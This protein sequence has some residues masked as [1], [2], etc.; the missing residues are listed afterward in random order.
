MAP[1]RL[2]PATSRA[3]AEHS[4]TEPTALLV[5]GFEGRLYAC[6]DPGFF[7][8]VGQKTVWT[9]FFFYLSSAYFTVYRGVQWFYCSEKSILRGGGGPKYSGGGGGVQMTISIETDITCDFPGGPDHYT[10]SGSA[11]GMHSK[12]LFLCWPGRSGE[13]TTSGF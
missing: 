5:N 13:I 12:H 4:T 7:V 3:Q 10:P 11:H 6:A 1:V 2:K 8:R 9:T